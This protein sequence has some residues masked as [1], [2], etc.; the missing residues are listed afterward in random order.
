MGRAATPSTNSRSRDC[1]VD[2][3]RQPFIVSI[4]IESQGKTALP[5]DVCSLVVFQLV[6]L[7]LIAISL[8]YL[9]TDA[10][11]SQATH[12]LSSLL[13]KSLRGELIEGVRLV[14]IFP[15]YENRSIL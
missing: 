15:L 12:L 3:Q 10:N 14:I 4:Q 2:M 6:Q 8:P 9:K 11:R 13:Y 5:R 1:T 7:G